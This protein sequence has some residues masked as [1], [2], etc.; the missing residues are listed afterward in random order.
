ME[1]LEMVSNGEGSQDGRGCRWR[2]WWIILR[3]AIVRLDSEGLEYE[4]DGQAV[5]E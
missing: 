3:D 5:S 1:G 2:F 4:L